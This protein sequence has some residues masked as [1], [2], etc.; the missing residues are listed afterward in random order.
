[1]LEN[2]LMKYPFQKDQMYERFN[3]AL[4]TSTKF[5]NWIILLKDL[6]HKFDSKINH[7]GCFN[8]LN[9]LGSLL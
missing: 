7:E 2:N 5:L 1:M 4:I 9:L 8:L 6:K 3:H